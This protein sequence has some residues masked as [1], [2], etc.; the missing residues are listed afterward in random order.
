[1]RQNPSWEANSRL[2]SP[3]IP[4]PSCKPKIHCRVHRIPPLDPYPEPDESSSRLPAVFLT[5]IILP[6][7][8]RSTERSLHFRFSYN[9]TAYRSHSRACYVP[10]PLIGKI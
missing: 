1:M 9:N 6:S 7:T 8:P 2:C 4:P 3:E 10:C 5:N